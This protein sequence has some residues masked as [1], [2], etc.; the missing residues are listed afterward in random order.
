MRQRRDYIVVYK[1]G[2]YGTPRTL[3]FTFDNIYM[4]PQKELEQIAL[5]CAKHVKTHIGHTVHLQSICLLTP[6][7]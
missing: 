4:G 2:T 1:E 6:L 5:E 3:A 7:T